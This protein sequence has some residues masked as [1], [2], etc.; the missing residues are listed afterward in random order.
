LEPPPT[1]AMMDY[2]VP[3]PP[4]AE[5][6]YV[7]RPVLYFSAP[8]F[9]FAP[10]PPPPVYFCPPPPPDFVVLPPPLPVVGLFVLPQPV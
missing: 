2:D 3:P 8:D 6:V 9:G 1:F 7:D 10:P 5:V 4:P